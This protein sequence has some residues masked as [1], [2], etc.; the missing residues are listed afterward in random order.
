MAQRKLKQPASG[1]GYLFNL[2]QQ[3][4]NL[5][6]DVPQS[7][8]RPSHVNCALVP[9]LQKH[10]T[11]VCRIW[12]QMLCQGGFPATILQGP[13]SRFIAMSAS[14][15]GSKA[16]S[17]ISDAQLAWF[18][19]CICLFKTD[20]RKIDEHCH[21]C[22]EKP[23]NVDGEFPLRVAAHVPSCPILMFL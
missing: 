8:V 20:K 22:G 2:Q 16:E 4:A 23:A 19:H 18:G 14:P 11:A 17:F 10:D 13:Q 9:P 7:I 21:S 15:A 1:Q 12:P 5:H 3:H 6:E